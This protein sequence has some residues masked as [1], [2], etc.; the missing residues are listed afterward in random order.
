MIEVFSYILSTQE[1]W[2]DLT[3][4]NLRKVLVFEQICLSSIFPNAKQE[5]KIQLSL[6]PTN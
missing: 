4:I 5:N 1:N 3:S 6:F 2:V